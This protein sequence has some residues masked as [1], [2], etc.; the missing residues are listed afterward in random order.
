MPDK[1]VRHNE[2]EKGLM[3][4]QSESARQRHEGY[5]THHQLLQVVL[6][7]CSCQEKPPCRL[8]LHEVLIT[9]ALEVLEHVSFVENAYL[10]QSSSTE[11]QIRRQQTYLPL[12]FLEELAVIFGPARK[13][14]RRHQYIPSIAV[15]EIIPKLGPFILAPIVRLD[16]Q[17]RCEAVELSDPVLK[18]GWAIKPVRVS[19]AI[20]RQS[21]QGAYGTTIRWRKFRS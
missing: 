12:H 20:R 8:N 13:V 7:R 18:C 6:Q 5:H 19:L 1:Q 10:R 9:T 21:Y 15:L 17:I 2:V 3:V 4:A 14:V 16:L 11:S